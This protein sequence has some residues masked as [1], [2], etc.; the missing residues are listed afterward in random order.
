[1]GRNRFLGL[2]RWREGFST[3]SYRTRRSNFYRSS[4]ILKPSNT[5]KFNPQMS[6]VRGNTYFS[7]NQFF[8]AFNKLSGG[9]MNFNGINFSISGGDQQTINEKTYGYNGA[10]SYKNTFSFY[11]NSIQNSFEKSSD[12]SINELFIS[13]SQRGDVGKNNALL[14]A[15]VGGAMKFDN[16][17]YKVNILHLKC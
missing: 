7:K 15:M 13:R 2:R 3:D 11:E 9:G 17:K 1:M 6:T 14:S 10:I 8:K 5:L 4:V 16:A 12:K